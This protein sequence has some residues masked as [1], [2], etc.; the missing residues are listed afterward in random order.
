M[1]RSATV[2][3]LLLL[4]SA[5]ASAGPTG[6][7]P[8]L[9][10]T[11]AAVGDYPSVVVLEVGQYLCTGTLI[12]KEWVLTAAHC[13]QGISLSS[14]RVHFNTVDLFR[15]QGTV[16]MAA[17]AI[18]KPNFDQRDLGHNDI[19]LIKLSEPMTE[20]APLPVNLDPDK[21]PVGIDVTMVG[22]GAT[23]QGGG[24]SVG[25]EY[26]VNQTSVP[27]TFAGS[28]ADLLCFSQT[29]GK[30]KCEGDS[31]GPSFAMVNGTLTQVGI[32]SF[33]DMN[34]TQFG[35]DTRTDA[36]KAFIL[37]YIPQLECEYDSDC[38]DGR[39]C[40]NKHC[41][42]EPFAPGGVGA[43]CAMA[44]DCDSNI[45]ASAG[46]DHYCSMTCNVGADNACPDGLECLDTGDGTDGACWP[47]DGGGCCSATGGDAATGLF[48]F[49]FL[50]F[51][52]GRRRRRARR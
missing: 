33:G 28:D 6:E 39:R 4:S 22:F 52:F 26:V 27:C 36:E 29:S 1:S 21:A 8:I 25:V 42:T 44:S 23:A 24:G 43:D 11:Q 31:G 5:V 37:Q 18:P 51:V 14:I 34:C 40:F 35:A 41:I 10:G 47:K 46:D 30:G 49:A 12:D 3:C 20:I 17:M 48:G 2:A 9:G 13:L 16:R 19:G 32:T 15:S 50:G 38:G 7:A 45:C